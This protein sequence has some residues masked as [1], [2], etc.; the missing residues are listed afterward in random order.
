MEHQSWRKTLVQHTLVPLLPFPVQKALVAR[1]EGRRWRR[2]EANLLPFWLAPA[3]RQELAQRNTQ[4]MVKAERERRFANP[5]HAME[6]ATLYPPEIPR[7]FAGWPM[8]I[9]NPWADLRLQAFMLAIPPEQKF[10]PHPI[11]DND[12]A[13]A[14]QIVRR[15]LKGILPESIRTRT[16]QTHFASQ[17]QQDMQNSWPA[18]EEAFGSAARAEIL[19][20]G[21]LDQEAF[22]ARLTALREGEFEVDLPYLLTV[23]GLESWLRTFRL[24]HAQQVRVPAWWQPIRNDLA[25]PSAPGHVSA[26]ST[27]PQPQPAKLCGPVKLSSQR[28]EVASV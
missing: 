4:L 23:L 7:P 22:F 12:Y 21:W 28:K 14:K 19:A 24:P 20:L 9:W 8:E 10:S 1:Y 11:D 15:G 3:L 17:F 27:P 13:S 16:R 18:L 26:W 25:A 5:T 6:A 2:L